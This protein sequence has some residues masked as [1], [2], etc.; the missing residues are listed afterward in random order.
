MFITLNKYLKT[1]YGKELRDTLANDVTVDLIIDF[2]ELPVFNASTDA[3]ITK[4]YKNIRN[5]ETRYFPIKTLENLDLFKTTS[6]Q[7]LTTIKD[8]NE[9]KF[10]N[11]NDEKILNKIY[12]NS[13]SLKKFSN[14]RIYSG[15]KTGLN[16]AFV[17]KD[18]SIAQRLLNSESSPIIKKYAQSIDIGRWKI[19]DDNKFFIATGY[20]IDV[21]NLYP[22]I[23][24]YLYQF[25]TELEVRCD[26]GINFYNLR[27]CAYYDEFEKVKIIYIHT[28]KNH[29]F[30]L[31]T[32]GHYINN[33]CYMIVSDSCFLFCFLNSK[34]FQYFK[35]LK[36]VAYGDGQE[37][38]RCKLDY[39]KMVTVPIKANVDETPYIN[40]VKEVETQVKNNPLFDTSQYEQ[41]INQM[42][43][44]TYGLSEEEIKIIEESV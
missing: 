20:D 8:S 29:K 32:E 26:R 7:F 11:D 3:A 27:S 4:I 17:I 14:D 34:L 5:I 24:N 44:Q 35:R 1:K 25:K 21:E 18:K 13:I 2:F 41:T 43:Y 12:D 22:T 9:W 10:V 15:I 42:I 6:G 33:S 40:I 31:D 16:K 38:G 37:A 23:Y 39:N 19:N 30:Y 36:F 28:A